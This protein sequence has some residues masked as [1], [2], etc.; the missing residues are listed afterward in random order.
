MHERILQRKI[1]RKKDDE[2]TKRKPS[3]VIS[4]L[5]LYIFLLNSVDNWSFAQSF[6]FAVTV[7]TTI[8]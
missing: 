1:L 5:N 6:F 7:V 2:L 3:D 8:G 4:D